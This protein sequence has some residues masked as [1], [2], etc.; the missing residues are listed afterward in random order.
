MAEQN[1]VTPSPEFVENEVVAL[2]EGE[3]EA[4]NPVVA[5]LIGEL[6]SVRQERAGVFQSLAAARQQVQRLEK[7]AVELE[8]IGQ[9]YMTD[10]KTQLSV[11]VEAPKVVLPK[12]RNDNEGK[13]K[14]VPQ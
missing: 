11:P 13:L 4:S 7:R 3:S 6:R 12:K 14:A 8:G 1:L 10:V 2:L 9:K 5:Y